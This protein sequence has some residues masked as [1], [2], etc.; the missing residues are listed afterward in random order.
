MNEMAAGDPKSWLVDSDLDWGQDMKRL[1]EFFQSKGVE[2]ATLSVIETGYGTLLGHKMAARLAPTQSRQPGWHAASASALVRGTP[3]WGQSRRPDYVVGHSIYVWH[4]SPE[5]ADAK[6]RL[7]ISTTPTARVFDGDQAA[8]SGAWERL[9]NFGS[10]YDGTL[11]FSNRAGDSVLLNF[12][13]KSVTLVYTKANNRGVA[14]VVIDGAV[15]G[16]LDQYSAGVEWQAAREY[17]L[18]E[19][20]KHSIELRVTGRRNSQS[21]NAYADIDAFVVD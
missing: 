14:E 10:A 21:K 8:M 17:S 1:G 15:I 4:I 12:E 18:P 9:T 5:E 20:G 11:S 3:V 6:W 2:A 16:E 19:S 7:R 13:G